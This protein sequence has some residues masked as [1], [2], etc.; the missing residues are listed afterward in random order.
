MHFYKKHPIVRKALE[1]LNCNIPHNAIGIR[2]RLYSIT[3]L[4]N[5]NLFNHPGGNVLIRIN[6][7]TDITNLFETHHLN[8]KLAEHYLNKL[9]HIGYYKQKIKYNFT[10]YDKL[11]DVVFNYF[12][13]RKSRQM[14]KFTKYIKETENYK[15]N[16]NS[17]S[18]VVLNNKVNKTLNNL[19][20]KINKKKINK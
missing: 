1:D 9:P 11:R 6:E 13:T 10:T 15:I 14:N 7:G 18:L 2:G 12:D 3:A 4:N 8:I 20:K 19:S 16:I 5:K 17:D